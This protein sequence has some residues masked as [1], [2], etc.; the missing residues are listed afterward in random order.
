MINNILKQSNQFRNKLSISYLKKFDYALTNLDKNNKEEK[1]STKL[2]D[3]KV[4]LQTK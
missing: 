2:S 1:A 4:Q 3:L